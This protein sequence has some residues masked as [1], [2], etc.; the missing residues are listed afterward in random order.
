MVRKL[1]FLF[2]AMFFVCLFAGVWPVSAVDTLLPGQAMPIRTSLYSANSNYRLDFQ[3]DGNVVIYRTSNGAAKWATGTAGQNAA[4]QFIFQS[5]GNLV[6]YNNSVPLFYTDTAGR[7]TKAVLQN[8]GNLLIYAGSTPIWASSTL[9]NV[10]KSLYPGD[11]IYS[12]DAGY[13]LVH[14]T[15]GNVVIYR[16][17][18]WNGIWQSGTSGQATTQLVLQSDGNL[19][20]YNGSTP[21]F[22]TGTGGQGAVTAEMQTDGRFVLRRSDGRAV[23][24]TPIVEIKTP[25]I[26]NTLYGTE[27]IVIADYVATALPY[28]ADPTGVADSTIAIQNALNA[29][30]NSGGGTVY[31]PAGTYRVTNTIEVPSFVTLRG[32]WRDA[33]VGTGSY[34]TVIRAE[35]A[36]GD[37]GPVLFQI[38]GS[39]GVMGLT[40]FYP[41][42]NASAP[43]AYNYTF[44]I[45]TGSWSTMPGNYMLSSIINCTMLNSYR[46]IGI[47]ALDNTKA[48]ELSTVKNVKGTVLYRGAVAYNGADVGTWENITF[49]NSYWANAGAAYNA[50]SLTTL[51]TWTRANGIAF[52]FGDLEWDQFFVLTC[53][54]YNIGI[55]IVAGSRQRFSGQFLWANIQN[56][57]IAVKVDTIDT[58]WGMSFLRS[59]LN[60]SSKS[61]QNSTTGYVQVCDSTLTGARSG[62]VTVTAPGTSPTFYTQSTGPKVTRSVL[63]NVTK[64]PYNAPY[65]FPQTGLPASDATAAIQSALND[66]GNAGGGVVYLPAGWYRINTHLT[67]PANVE[68]RGSSSVPTRDQDGFSYG[69]V[70]LGYEGAG[71]TTPDSATALVTLNGNKAGIRG[72]RFFYPNNNP[73]TGIAAYPYTIRGNGPNQYV[74]N[75]GLTGVYKGVDFITHRCDNH[76]IRKV[77]GVAYRQFIAIGASTQGWVEGCLSNGAAVARNGFGISGWVTETNIFAQV[78]DPITRPNEILLLINGASSENVLNNFAYGVNIGVNT[79]SCN[80]NIFNLG[81]D[82]LGTG[83]YSAGGFNTSIKLLNV[84]KYLGAY[85]SHLGTGTITIFNPMTL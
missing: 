39:A 45:P 76:Y 78:I 46:G 18:D 59:V 44:N 4:P 19:V 70:L 43:V 2:P 10:G 55:N 35:L 31:I 7:G 58:R 28:N 8:D 68:L 74:V 77:V 49:K 38:G 9:L 5:D 50:P 75:I 36:T 66:A 17:S 51:N 63:Y 21:V 84:M 69:T 52:T 60:G 47:N 71:T 82:N 67:V 29:C 11:A 13:M 30:F 22:A 1:G 37:N 26:I 3:G 54:D 81:T 62:T 15:D 16:T 24:W 42:Q 73:A 56:T 23:W 6:L 83:G 40:T 41:N 27:D 57:T 65:S 33:D 72:I 20:L 53:S 80:V 79:A 34:G 48:H 64:A 61:I 12:A 25:V 14:Q 32:D 85:S